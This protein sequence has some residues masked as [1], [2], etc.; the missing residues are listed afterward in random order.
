MSSFASVPVEGIIT[1]NEAEDGGILDTLSPSK[2]RSRFAAYQ[3]LDR[4]DL[5]VGSCM[6]P[7]CIA[8]CLVMALIPLLCGA[9]LLAP[10]KTQGAWLP[11]FNPAGENNDLMTPSDVG[12][13]C[14]RTIADVSLKVLSPGADL[15]SLIAT[16]GSIFRVQLPEASMD[17]TLPNPGAD[18]VGATGLKGSSGFVE[19]F[20]VQVG[21]SFAVEMV[22]TF[23]R[24]DKVQS[25]ELRVVPGAAT[26]VFSLS[27]VW[28]SRVVSPPSYFSVVLRNPTDS[29]CDSQ[30]WEL[31]GIE[32]ND[33][34]NV[35]KVK[36]YSSINGLYYNFTFE[37]LR[38]FRGPSEIH[39]LHE[40][41]RATDGT[42]RAATLELTTAYPALPR[43]FN[44]YVLYQGEIGQLDALMNRDLV[45]NKD[46]SIIGMSC[47]PIQGRL[48]RISLTKVVLSNLGRAGPQTGEEGIHIE[49]TGTWFDRLGRGH[50]ED[51]LVKMNAMSDYSPWG[52]GEDNTL[53]GNAQDKFAQVCQPSGSSVQISI[54]FWTRD[55]S[56]RVDFHGNKLALVVYDMDTGDVDSNGQRGGVETVEAHG[57]VFSSR[58]KDTTIREEQ[59]ADG[60]V[61]FSASIFGDGSDNPTDP[62]NLTP[63]QSTKV[64]V[65]LYDQPSQ[66]DLIIGSSAL[67]NQKEPGPRF[68]EMTFAD[69]VFCKESVVGHICRHATRM[70]VSPRSPAVPDLPSGLQAYYQ[71]APQPHNKD[72][73]L[74]SPAYQPLNPVKNSEF[75]AAGNF[76]S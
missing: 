4:R 61:K 64:V 38:E 49:A 74:H 53:W 46:D 42:R 47:G 28:K 43:L 9:L 30:G 10:K 68:T 15:D 40:S 63:Q 2:A 24:A 26:I 60:W 12:P 72:S 35:K 17:W 5:E 67:T 69:R 21:S 22:L 31:V 33:H 57:F 14:P 25:L 39:W 7:L 44:Y 29:S 73:C 19:F 16:P 48:Y 20:E 18:I 75:T 58:S 65:L 55:G 51:I 66:I 34:L 1:A 56:A 23:T 41:S 76:L 27:D 62:D 59:L 70:P 54:S 45:V 71:A 13:S 8:L 3:A 37:V 50:H 36:S 32:L 11:R 6:R 52:N